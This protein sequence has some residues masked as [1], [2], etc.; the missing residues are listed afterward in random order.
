MM[1]PRLPARTRFPALAARAGGRGA[2]FVCT[3]LFAAANAGC[4]QGSQA[5]SG[6]RLSAPAHGWLRETDTALATEYIGLGGETPQSRCR[7]P[8]DLDA[9]QNGGNRPLLADRPRAT[10]QQLKALDKSVK[11]HDSVATLGDALAAQADAAATL[12]NQLASTGRAQ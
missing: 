11:L 7:S 6:A 9:G 5:E 4:E 12:H 2:L 8:R 3:C 1:P 10:L